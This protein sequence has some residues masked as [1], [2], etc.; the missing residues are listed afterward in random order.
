MHIKLLIG[1][2]RFDIGDGEIPEAPIKLGEFSLRPTVENDLRYA[3]LFNDMY[4]PVVLKYK[5]EVEYEQNESDFVI[6]VEKLYPRLKNKKYTIK[7]RTRNKDKYLGNNRFIDSAKITMDAIKNKVMPLVTALHLYQRGFVNPFPTVIKITRDDG[8]EMS[9]IIRG[10]YVSKSGADFYSLR[11]DELDGFSK[12]ITDTIKILPR[13]IKDEPA[14]NYLNR[15]LMDSDLTTDIISFNDNKFAI[16][17]YIAGME[18]LFDIGGELRFTLSLY[19]A[20]ALGQNYE[21]RKKCKDLIS[22]LYGIRSK[23]AHGDD[24][25][26]TEDELE[27]L[28]KKAEYILRRLLNNYLQYLAKGRRKEDFKKDIEA[29]MLGKEAL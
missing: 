22:E 14:F 20:F 19:A 26:K 4:L 28:S 11:M 12:F 18:S 7:E 25:E 27:D 1:L 3:E 8:V 9:P 16:L 6:A 24:V 13:A 23:I 10:I 2:E 21:E 15:G 17:D 29:K 5:A